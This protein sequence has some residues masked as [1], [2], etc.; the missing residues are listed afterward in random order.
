MFAYLMVW[1]LLPD[2]VVLLVE[3]VLHLQVRAKVSA[4]WGVAVQDLGNA[5]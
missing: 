3:R 1:S 2:F 4:S 5:Q